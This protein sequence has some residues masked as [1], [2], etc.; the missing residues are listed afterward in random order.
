MSTLKT[1]LISNNT[2]RN[3]KFIFLVWWG[4]KL[5]MTC[6]YSVII[7]LIMSYEMAVQIGV[8]NLLTRENNEKKTYYINIL[9][10]LYFVLNFYSFCEKV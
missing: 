4:I 8:N 9:I 1:Q 2:E 10:H 7:H 3:S 6:K 5:T